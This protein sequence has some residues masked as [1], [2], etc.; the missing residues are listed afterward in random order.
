MVAKYKTLSDDLTRDIMR[1]SVFGDVPY[2]D[3][4][5]MSRRE[6]EILG[7]TIKE[8]IEAGNPNKKSQ[9]MV[10]GQVNAPQG[11][12]PPKQEFR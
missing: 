7:E 3:I 1:M 8:K 9:Q 12:T 4:I 11:P 5:D 2:S 10:A 6:R